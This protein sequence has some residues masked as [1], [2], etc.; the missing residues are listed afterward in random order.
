[1][2]AI[3]F[4]FFQVVIPSGALIA[5]YFVAHLG[6]FENYSLYGMYILWGASGFVAVS[7]IISL[8]TCNVYVLIVH[9]TCQ[10]SLSSITTAMYI[11]W[12]FSLQNACQLRQVA[13][14]GCD[15]CPCAQTESC[16]ISDFQED[17]NC[18]ECTAMPSSGCMLFTT[19][20]LTHILLLVIGAVFWLCSII[21]AVVN[22]ASFLNQFQESHKRMVR[23]VGLSLY[24]D[25]QTKLLAAGD[26]P[27]VSPSLLQSW[28]SELLMSSDIECK[29]SATLCC[30]SLKRRGYTLAVIRDWNGIW[31][32]TEALKGLSGSP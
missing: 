8:L 29:N 1:M 26:A 18:A 14:I 25:H 15:E 17:G 23:D 2:Q 27:T 20:G 12:F 31:T 4:Y 32:A 19:V 13:M 28:V 11:G 16:T 10:V 3:V 5:L 6:E 24:I 21:S 9:I 30:K 7:G 22:L